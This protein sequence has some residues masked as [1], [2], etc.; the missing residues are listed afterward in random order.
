MIKVSPGFCKYNHFIHTGYVLAVCKHCY[1]TLGEQEQEENPRSHAQESSQATPGHQTY[2]REI[3]FKQ[4]QNNRSLV[5]MQIKD[6]ENSI[7]QI[8]SIVKRISTQLRVFGRLPL[9]V[10]M[11]AVLRVHLKYKAGV[12]PH[13]AHYPPPTSSPALW[14]KNRLIH[15]DQ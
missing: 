15:S 14:I 4:M 5:L 13:C 10:D 9:I 2:T 7:R 11:P 8:I 6:V 1:Q 12:P 3:T